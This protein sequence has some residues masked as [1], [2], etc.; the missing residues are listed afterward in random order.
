M[1]S[2]PVD[3]RPFSVA[4]IRASL[5]AFAIGKGITAPLSFV[6]ILMLAAVMSS[7]EYAGYIASVAVLEISIVIGTFGVEWVTQTAIANI[8]VH[9][10][11]RQLRRAALLLAALP[12]VPYAVLAA[13]LWALAPTVSALLGSVAPVEVLRLYAVVLLLEGPT[14]ML[15]DSLLAVL[16]QQRTAQVSQVLRVLVTFSIVSVTILSGGTVE[17]VD[18]ARAEIV[19]ACVAFAAASV[20]LAAYLW[21]LPR[22]PGAD[23]S[24]G[25]WFGPSSVRFAGHAYTSLLLMLLIGTDVMTALVAHF[26]G[27]EST[28][29]FGFVVRLVETARRYLPMDVFWG[30]I[31]PATIGRHEESGRRLEALMRDCNRLVEINLLAV[32]L[33][34]AVAIAVGDP[35]VRLLSKGNVDFPPML[36]VA[37]LPLLALHTVRRTVELV[38]YT[39]GHAARFAR[40]AVAGLLAPPLSAALLV[41][42]G[43]VHGAPLGVLVADTLF[44]LL[45]LRAIGA[46]GDPIRFNLGRWGRI[47]LAAVAAGG[48]GR[49]AFVAASGIADPLV[50]AVSAGGAAAIAAFG[51]LVVALRIVDGDDRNWVTSLLRARARLG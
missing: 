45:A 21:S 40:A 15:R 11:P 23:P 4:R 20:A 29:A 7:G 33:A 50:V 38:A 32:G 5:I 3:D 22:T 51:G 28:A 47:T 24:I 49:A 13:L 6:L 14:R 35:L 34:L 27:A 30:V 43:A 26:L 37:L 17:A 41:L 12:V 36:L 31:R 18:V 48:F 1:A 44:V 42:T 8:R 46:T 9:G 10:N 25:A 19:A 2:R 39:R 16:L